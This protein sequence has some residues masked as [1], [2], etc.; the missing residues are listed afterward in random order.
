MGWLSRFI[1]SAGGIK[2]PEPED[3]EFDDTENKV[4]VHLL[5]YYGEV[6]DHKS[7]TIDVA[8][9]SEL[10]DNLDWEDNF[11]QVVCTLRPGVSMEVGGS[12][13]ESDGL[14][15]V[16]QNRPE[17]I[18][19]VSSDGPDSRKEMIEIMESFIRGTSCWRKKFGVE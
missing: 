10:I 5:S 3:I 17:N 7:E 2:I 8:E 12:L 18:S 19:Y 11:Y 13:N 16:Y 9:V 6:H 1:L 15:A 4:G 14:A